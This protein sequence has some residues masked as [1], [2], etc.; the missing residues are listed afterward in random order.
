MDN[1]LTPDVTDYLNELAADIAANGGFENKS[2]EEAIQAAH[3][4]RR[5]FA[6]EMAVGSTRRA[7]MARKAIQAS[8]WHGA[9][10]VVAKERLAMQARD[11][12]RGFFLACESIDSN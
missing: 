1:K 12:T 8:V 4:R 9:Q 11:C 10:V 2:L 3:Q 7:Q 5:D 6:M